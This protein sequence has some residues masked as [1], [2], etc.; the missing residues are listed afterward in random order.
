M[1]TVLRVKGY[2][3]FF[4]MADLGEP[5]HIHV[6]KENCIAKF[7][8]DPVRLASSKGFKTHELNE[9]NTIIVDNIDLIKERWNERI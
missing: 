3:F 4:V 7:W 1:P 6:M 9:I 2:R 5:I 8:L